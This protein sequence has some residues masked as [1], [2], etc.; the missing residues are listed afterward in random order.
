MLYWYVN[1]TSVAK[2]TFYVTKY[3]LNKQHSVIQK[4]EPLKLN[5][6]CSYELGGPSLNTVRVF[7]FISISRAALRPSKSQWYAFAGVRAEEL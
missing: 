2:Q 1:V 5:V 3:F 6:C 7:L 4:F